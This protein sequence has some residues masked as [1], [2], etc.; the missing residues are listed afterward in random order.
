MFSVLIYVLTVRL[1]AACVYVIFPAA[2]LVS[3][4]RHTNAHTVVFRLVVFRPFPSEVIL[5]R[6]KSSDEDGIRCM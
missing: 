4:L 5:A 2:S 6:V 3:C 1:P